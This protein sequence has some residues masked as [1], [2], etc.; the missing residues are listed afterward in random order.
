MSTKTTKNSTESCTNRERSIDE[1]FGGLSAKSVG[2][3]FYIFSSDTNISAESISKIL[4]E[5]ESAISTGLRELRERGLLELKTI[6]LKNGTFSRSTYVT[7]EGYRFFAN[8]LALI[9]PFNSHFFSFFYNASIPDSSS[10]EKFI[11]KPVR[12]TY[13][14]VSPEGFNG[15]STKELEIQRRETEEEKRI[16][17]QK[18]EDDK[19]AWRAKE[20]VK[21]KARFKSRYDK[22]DKRTWTPTDVSFEFSDRVNNYWHIPPWL[23]TQ[24]RFRMILADMRRRHDTNGHIECAMMGIFFETEPVLERKDGQHLMLRFF[25]RFP[26]LLRIAR[27]R[28]LDLTEEELSE[29]KAS[30]QE[31]ARRSLEKLLALVDL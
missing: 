10:I 11:P 26:T 14:V 15:P 22:P 27:E 7:E 31:Q 9:T 20:K 21:Q 23:V 16:A 17:L 8:V 4:K 28:C 13:G 18:I 2:I 19:E 5:G 29:M 12:E 6:Q 3:L 25:N 1:V 24:T 30:E